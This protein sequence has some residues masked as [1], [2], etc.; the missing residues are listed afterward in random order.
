[1]EDLTL[2]P[3]MFE[4]PTRI[5]EISAFFWRVWTD[6]FGIAPNFDTTRFGL[7][8]FFVSEVNILEETTSAGDFFW[9]RKLRVSHFANHACDISWREISFLMFIHVGLQRT[10]EWWIKLTFFQT[11][12]NR[13]DKVA[14]DTF[15]GI[16]DGLA[17]AHLHIFSENGLKSFFLQV[18]NIS[19]NNHLR[20]FLTIGADILNR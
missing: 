19:R 16:K 14:A 15:T 1:M 2:K 3:G 11:N 10:V 5:H 18:V 8:G 9:I 4:K 7:V 20:D 13:I 12:H 6:F 17:I